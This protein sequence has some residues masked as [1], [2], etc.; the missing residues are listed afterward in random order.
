MKT[1]SLISLAL[2]LIILMQ[3]CANG[4][5][6]EA[7][8]PINLRCEFSVDPEC[9]DAT[10]PRLSWEMKSDRRADVQTA[11]RILVASSYT[12][13]ANGVG[14]I[15]D[16]GK[17]EGDES[18]NVAFAG[19]KLESTKDY[20]WKVMFWDA[21][22]NPSTWSKTAK[23]TMGLL[24]KE[25][26]Q[27]AQWIAFKDQETWKQEWDAQKEKER[28]TASGNGTNNLGT[29]WP[30]Y[31]GKDSTIFTLKEMGNYDPAP[32][33]RKE[34]TTKGKVSRA[35]LFICGLG[36]YI[37]YLNGKRVGDREL[38]PAWT[39]FDQRSLYD[40]Y[41]VTSQIR[42]NNAI[43]V[44]LGRGQYEPICNDIWGL[45]HSAWI[46]EPKMIALLRIEYADGSL[47]FITSDSSWKTVGG[48]VVYDDTRHG[49]LYDAREEKDGWDKADYDDS[50]WKNASP[51]EWNCTLAAQTMPPVRKFDP[52]LPVKT[53][54]SMQGSKV[55]DIGHQVA[56]WA[57]VTVKGKRGTRVLV[58]YT[59]RPSNKE[60]CPDLA[61]SCYEFSGKDSLYASFY[62][63]CTNVRQ[64]NGYIL[65][66]EGD[67]T[68]EC[69]FSYKGFRYIRVWADDDIQIKYVA[70]I[71]VH[72]DFEVTGD[73]TCSDESIN[74][75]QK[76][77]VISMFSNFESIP[78]DCPHREK[79]GWTCDTYIVSKASMYNFNMTLF[80]ENWV[81]DLAETQSAAGGLTTVA[82]STG[83]D[84]SLSTTWPIAVINVPLDMY[85]YYADSKVLADNYDCMAKFAES[86]LLREVPGK[87]DIINDVLGDWVSPH[88]EIDD[89]KPR[90]NDM[91]PPEG[92]SFYGT[93]SHYLAHSKLGKISR[94]LGKEDRATYYDERCA[95][96]ADSFNKE[97]YDAQSHSY[98]G[99]NPTGYRQSTNLTALTY[100]MVPE[101]E[102]K[103]VQDELINQIHI[104][105]DH[106]ST[107][108]VGMQ[109]L[110]DYMP[111]LDAELTYKMAI[112]PTYPS[113]G[114][115]VAKG[116]T[117]MWE[118]WDGY[119]SQNHL[120]FCLISEYFFKH[121][122]GIQ[123]DPQK[124]GF[125]HFFIN[126]DFIASL[127]HAKA[128]YNSLAGRI[129]SSWKRNGNSIELQILVPGNTT[130]T[131]ILP[132][133]AKNIQESG[134]SA[135]TDCEGILNIDGS[136]IE[137]GSG[138][139][140]FTFEK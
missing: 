99:S 69:M 30:W 67:E 25:D 35:D 39:N 14:D 135:S 132:E 110:M 28:L 98:H 68:F 53:Y 129:E 127:D 138:K 11:Y 90:Q 16:S 120:P 64:Q 82:P 88:K 89:T 77:S 73:F 36:Y 128:H 107:G 8:Q 5:K 78:T 134:K 84:G 115:M 116:A 86:S 47:D 100:G 72:T 42:S 50:A 41:D 7:L 33:F 124:P 87:K 130:A 12:T 1:R 93:T 112:Q 44:M 113:W 10:A 131:V 133:D 109:S 70:G 96:I 75:M 121:L 57:K 104:N 48:P 61:P 15:W 101:E 18:F 119:D 63:K 3:S 66:G 13:L 45:C 91:A 38:N 32:L 95:Q 137:V 60:I 46:D 94:I 23:W 26:W 51:V 9:I 4:E 58:E 118:T 92:L 31:N 123:F 24:S 122:A 52:V 49:E 74:T 43:G 22:G 111:E 102:I 62:D 85:N 79:Q 55:Y 83:Y 76:N 19:S 56:G 27:D 6:E 40:R 139:Y 59:E 34:F 65:K 21:E 105:D 114:Y 17:V 117:A 97:F 71:P 20:F 2:G 140:T 81:K 29:S 37:P 106:L 126:P 54:D 103:G 125:K 136:R 108:F 80:F